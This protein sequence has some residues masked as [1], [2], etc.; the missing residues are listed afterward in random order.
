MND[1]FPKT[2]KNSGTNVTF[3][4]WFEDFLLSQPLFFD[5]FEIFCTL[6]PRGECRVF[7]KGDTIEPVGVGLLPSQN[8]HRKDRK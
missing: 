3:D 2:A 5:H 7:D 6:D 4:L 8:E 1:I